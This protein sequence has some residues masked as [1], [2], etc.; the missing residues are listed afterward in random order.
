MI[1][2][3]FMTMRANRPHFKQLAYWLTVVLLVSTTVSCSGEAPQ[4]V[5]PS[6][7]PSTKNNSSTKTTSTEPVKDPLSDPAAKPETIQTALKEQRLSKD[8]F[9][10]QSDESPIPKSERGSFKG[11]NY[12]PIDLSYR[13][14]CK[15]KPCPSSE[16]I[17]MLVSQ[18]EARSY[19]CFGLL[20][21]KVGDKSCSLMALKNATPES[22]LEA[23]SL[24]VPFKDTTSGSETYGA[25]RYL[26]LQ[27]NPTG[28]YVL[29]FNLAFNPYCAYNHDYS[30]PLPPQQ[31]VLPVAIRA[32]E[33]TK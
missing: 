12:F 7:S 22:P 4:P 28:D 2:S 23:T 26:E 21:F 20:E 11:L 3:L 16:A 17:K 25:G 14:V 33:K 30:C 32:G 9:F 15:L 29:D 5:A 8:N 1:V 10:K 18:G 19:R 27:E 6:P 24:F 13:F 31:N